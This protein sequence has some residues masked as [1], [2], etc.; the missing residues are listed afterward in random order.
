MDKLTI[1]KLAIK[2]KNIRVIENNNI[3]IQ[4]IIKSKIKMTSSYD[5]NC[6]KKL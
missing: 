6:S 5:V 2:Q 1:T 4:K 3:L